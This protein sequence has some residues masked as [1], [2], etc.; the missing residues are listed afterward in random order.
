MNIENVL[1]IG[2][3]GFIGGH[4]AHELSKRGLCVT[5]PTRRRER[6]RHLLLLPTVDVVE[7]DVHDPDALDRLVVGQDA[8]INLVGVLQ[9]RSG[10]PYGHDFE[11]A[12]VALPR[13][14]VACAHR[15]GVSRLVHFSALRAAPN[16]P[17]QYLRSKAAGESVVRTAEPPLN[18]TILQPS[19]VFGPEDSF[20]NL[21][22]E[23][24]RRFPVL[25]LGAAGARFQPVYV[26]DVARIA[27][28]LLCNETSFGETYELCGPK[29]YTLR[30]L[31]TYVGKLIGHRRPILSLPHGLA[32]LQA[33]ALEFAPGALMSRDNLRSMEVD[34][35]AS[36][37]ALPFGYAP[38]A[39]ESI[40]P[41]Y[42]RQDNPHT[43]YNPIREKAGRSAER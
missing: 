28:D 38:T 15:S 43:R 30:Q 11:R 6:A 7:A 5:V 2:G 39:L 1:L 26:G 20:L 40:A 32:Y 25:P 33:L 36:G 23:L 35:V 17:S 12:H 34:N 16:A 14:I 24:A 41:G 42:L 10:Q 29:V 8:I 19:V 37:Q 9:S 27:V 22:A 3:S 4:I 13:K 31:V 18:Y 21:F